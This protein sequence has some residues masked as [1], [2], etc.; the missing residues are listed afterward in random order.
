MNQQWKRLHELADKIGIQGTLEILERVH[1]LSG[2]AGSRL[3]ERWTAAEKELAYKVRNDIAEGID[4]KETRAQL[5]QCVAVYADLYCDLHTQREA[6]A[7]EKLLNE[8][9]SILSANIEQSQTANG[10]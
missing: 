3:S 6:T 10:E 1:G 7:S 4:C 5:R 8:I 9:K 2:S